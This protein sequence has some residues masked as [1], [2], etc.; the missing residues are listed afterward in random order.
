MRKYVPVL[1]VDVCV[2]LGVGF[3]VEGSEGG[4][5]GG[6]GGG[7]VVVAKVLL[8]QVRVGRELDALASTPL[9]RTSRLTV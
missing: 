5:V 2:V 7:K 4:V 3:E 6:A 9:K 8:Q 1:L